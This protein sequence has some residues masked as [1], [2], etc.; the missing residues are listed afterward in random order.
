MKNKALIVAIVVAILILA[1]WF[2]FK[3]KD[4]KNNTS[5][6]TTTQPQASNANTS[7]LKKACDIYTIDLA[8]KY[9]GP[10]AKIGDTANSTAVKE[11]EDT[12]ISSC[13][14]EDGAEIPRIVN[15]QLIAAKTDRGKQW[16]K[17]SFENSPKE[18]AEA[19]GQAPPTLETIE[20]AGDKA[21][22]NPSLGQVNVLIGDGKY[23]LT[24]QGGTKDNEQKKLQIESLAKDLASK[25]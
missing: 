2:V 21:Y 23:F 7:N 16:N 20:G 14:Y 6:Q 18:T 22:R 11:G 8:Q 12:T 25:L 3:P 13:L 4:S 19:T 15:I 1:G 24:V 5:K 10:N 9:L 17:S